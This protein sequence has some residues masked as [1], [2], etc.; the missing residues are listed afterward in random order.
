MC[1]REEPKASL[2]RCTHAIS[3]QSGVQTGTNVNYQDHPGT[4]VYHAGITYH[5]HSTRITWYLVPGTWYL[6]YENTYSTFNTYYFEVHGICYLVCYTRY[7]V[8][9][10]SMRVKNSCVRCSLYIGARTLSELG[11]CYTYERTNSGDLCSMFAPPNSPD[12]RL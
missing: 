1:F 11:R 2:L 10:R 3:Y 12:Y 9:T 8:Y 4:D 5:Q 7:Q 6:V